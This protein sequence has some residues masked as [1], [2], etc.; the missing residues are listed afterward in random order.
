MFYTVDGKKLFAEDFIAELSFYF[1][2]ICDKQPAT[3]N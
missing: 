1:V 2:K 3:E